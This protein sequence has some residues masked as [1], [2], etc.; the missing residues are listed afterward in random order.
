MRTASALNEWGA[1][2]KLIGRKTKRFSVKP[3]VSFT[4]KRMRLWFNTGFL[5]YANL[6]LCL[7]GKL[8]FGRYDVIVSNDLDTL[9]PAWLVSRIRKKPLVYDTHEYFTEMAEL[10]TRP[11]VQKFWKRIENRIF[12]KLKT[13]YT[14]NKS[15]AELYSKEYGVAVHVVRNIASIPQIE[16]KTRAELRLPEDKFILIIQGTGINIGRGGEQAVQ[17]M[18]HLEGVLLLVIGSGTAISAMKKLANELQ[19]QEKVLFLEPLIYTELLQYTQASDIGLALDMPTNLNYRF[20]LPN[21]LFDFIHCSTPILSVALPEISQIVN[22]FH[23]GMLIADHQP[24]TIVNA[25]RKLQSSSNLLNTMRL[26][27][28]LATKELTW[29]KEKVSLRKVYQ[30]W[31]A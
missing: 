20:S 12:P 21:K 16:A 11:R 29:E 25:V 13:V 19:V 8:L 4:I 10:V 5:F 27:C 17:A 28:E 14:V 3:S 22:N 23:C 15:I 30:T 24:D 26:G 9:W 2:V 6:N 18:Q 1:T 31:L 7:F